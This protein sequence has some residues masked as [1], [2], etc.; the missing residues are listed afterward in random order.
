MIDDQPMCAV[1]CAFLK[2]L[3]QL[4]IWPRSL[5][6]NRFAFKMLEFAVRIS[7]FSVC[8]FVFSAVSAGST[9]RIDDEMR[10]LLH[11]NL[12]GKATDIGPSL[13]LRGA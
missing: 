8:L 12:P 6:S 3:S 10:R 11:P 4:V 7:P 13:Q 1:A 9:T 2:S 5:G